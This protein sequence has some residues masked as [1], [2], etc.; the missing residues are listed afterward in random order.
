M[1]WWQQLFTKKPLEQLLA[2]AE[3]DNRLRRVLG[4]IGLTS[5]GI[6]AI[7]G[8]GIFV[9]TGR[10]AA[11]EA[12]P[13]I[14]MSFVVAGVGCLFAALCYA[15]FASMAPVAG[16]AYTYAYTTIGELLA[17][18]IGWDLVLEYAM[19]CA[20]V[21]AS[22]S[23]YFN[24]FLG[25]LFGQGFK[26]PD[27]LI[28]DPFSTS[29][30]WLNLP[31]AVITLLVTVVLVIGIKESATTNAVLVGIKVGVVLFVIAVG[32]AFVNS[33]NWTSIPPRERI[34][35]QE[36]LTPELVKDTRKRVNTMLTEVT[37]LTATPA[38]KK[39]MADEI[40][41]KFWGQ[42][43]AY[44]ARSSEDTDD[45]FA[46]KLA[47]WKEEW[48]KEATARVA[49][50]TDEV[51]TEFRLQSLDKEIES[52]SPEDAAKARARVH[53]GLV[54]LRHNRLIREIKEKLDKKEL[55][56][57]QADAA[58][59][60]IKAD[61][62]TI[63]QP[64]TPEDK[65]LV[66]LI[67][68]AVNKDAPAKE[69]DKWGLLGYMGI[70]TTLEKID[71]LIRGPFA[72]YGLAGIIF[73]ASIVFFAYIGFDSI[74]TH[75]E[76]ARNPK[77]DV[78]MAILLSL[79][80]CTFL[81]IAVAAVLTGMVPYPEIDPD[82]AVA[83]AFTQKAELVKSPLLNWAGGL[84]ALGG[85]AGMTSVLL[86]TFLSQAR[87]FLAMARDGLL[88]PAIFGAVHHRFRTPHISTM[89]T[90]CTIAVVAAFT[91]ILALEEMVSIGT[92]M[93]FVI[94]CAAVWLLRHQSP[95]AVR[96]FRCPV[97]W[98]VAPLG[99]TV[100]LIMMLFLPVVTWLRLVIWLAV[101]LCIYFGYGMWR[102]TL[103]HP[104]AVKIQLA[105]DHHSGK[106]D[107]HLHALDAPA[108][109]DPLDG[110]DSKVNLKE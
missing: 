65:A 43:V 29:G 108:Y 68:G 17:W 81:Y 41:R 62:T 78:P 73:G 27:Y 57:A 36:T 50:L 28:H 22:W 67:L 24:T 51:L 77:G 83:T 44:P 25:V 69:T 48:N 54:D 76:E 90:G 79:F 60:K 42:V 98:L 95:N 58:I 70:N 35:P 3:G 105:G 4:K 8:A 49:L 13:A 96:P 89:L 47:A 46:K 20:C 14:M 38:T 86:I 19:A 91:P 101:G 2:E 33:A 23:K 11:Q 61:Q 31:A 56:R 106:S 9:M 93:A 21:A 30:A 26:V 85:L 52:L 53:Q 32:A 18:I 5:L 1:K 88:P 6:G 99:I 110:T 15:E 34:R 94:V 45:T 12:G 37:E 7:I 16:S 97:I 64:Q 107:V 55:D 84:I 74:S 71:K 100:N 63:D 102:S 80:I 39:T 87:I 40:M 75:A 10:V 82:A 104:H 59:E 103:R 66:A 92:L 72:P 109:T